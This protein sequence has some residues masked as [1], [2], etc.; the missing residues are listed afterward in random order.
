MVSKFMKKNEVIWK[1]CTCIILEYTR[2]PPLKSK[3]YL[4]GLNKYTMV[5]A[6]GPSPGNVVTKSSGAKKLHSGLELYIIAIILT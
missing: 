4:Q 2:G 6:R 3:L 1:G 5:S